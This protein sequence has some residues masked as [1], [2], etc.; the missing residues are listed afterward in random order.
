MIGLNYR[1]VHISGEQNVVSDLLSRWGNS[2]QARDEEIS[3]EDSK[4]AVVT[5]SAPIDLE[6]SGGEEILNAEGARARATNELPS[7]VHELS[8]AWEWPSVETIRKIQKKIS[9]WAE[10][11][12]HAL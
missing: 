3:R 12:H 7:S 5:H 2:A 4:Y 11:R 10:I 6:G 9:G 1:I 8:K